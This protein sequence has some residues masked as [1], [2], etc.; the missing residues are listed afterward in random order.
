TNDYA[1]HIFQPL[2]LV[3]KG[4]FACQ[5][6]LLLRAQLHMELGFLPPSLRCFAIDF[7][8]DA[9][10]APRALFPEI[11][12]DV[13]ERV[14]FSPAEMYLLKTNID[15][16][17][18]AQRIR[19]GDA[20][21]AWLGRIIPADVLER[22]TGTEA[23][24][25]PNMTRFFLA[26]WASAFHRFDTPWP[27]RLREHL[28]ALRR[29]GDALHA[30]T[31]FGIPPSAV[32]PTPSRAVSICGAGGGTGS[33]ASIAVSTILKWLA[34]QLGL[35]FKLDALVITG[36]YRQRNGHEMRKDAL[37]HALDMDI[38]ASVASDAVT[39]FQLGPDTTARVSGKLFDT[40]Q[41][42]EAYGRYEY[43]TRGML[44]AAARFLRY[45]YFTRAGYQQQK[46]V[47]NDDVYPALRTLSVTPSS[48]RAALLGQR[49]FRED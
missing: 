17:K 16:K 13:W 44:S 26:Y 45:T 21:V 35:D 22:Y 6:L 36:H 10:L 9:P 43:Q 3:A 31:A 14:E 32:A 39:E 7:A 27:E 30:L 2:L 19:R 5:A 4:G 46:D 24:Q 8:A 34:G 25:I 33:G 48:G 20:D 37:A 12:S 49:P 29:N 11:P 41:R 42:L 47:A 18:I 40:L 1:R 15:L 38:T 28:R 23:C